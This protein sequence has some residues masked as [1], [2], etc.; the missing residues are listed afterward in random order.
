MEHPILIKNVLSAFPN[1]EVNPII[2]P[3]DNT[4]SSSQ[5]KD[6]SSPSRCD[7]PTFSLEPS[8]QH[9]PSPAHVKISTGAAICGPSLFDSPEITFKRTHSG[10]PLSST[11]M[12][13]NLTLNTKRSFSVNDQHLPFFYKV[14]PLLPPLSKSI[15]TCLMK[16]HKSKFSKD[17]KE[18]GKY[19][20]RMN[21]NIDE[22]EDI[23]VSKHILF[24][25]YKL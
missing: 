13:H 25:N 7:S 15:D 10:L 12:S 5:H 11:P 16:W 3:Q 20:V 1:L 23:L 2:T 4:V 8:P 22:C 9:S 21:I 19:E 24:Y 14:L 18:N 17:K 6:Q